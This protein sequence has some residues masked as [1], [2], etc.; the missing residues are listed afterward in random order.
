MSAHVTIFTGSH[1]MFFI[2]TQ[3][4]TTFHFFLLLIKSIFIALGKVFAVSS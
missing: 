2:F 4:F 3:V 1:I